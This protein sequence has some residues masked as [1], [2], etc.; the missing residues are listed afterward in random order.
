MNKIKRNVY[1]NVVIFLVC[2]CLYYI[3]EMIIKRDSHWSMI[4]CAGVASVITGLLN[5]IYSYDM[6]LQ[7][8]ML[9][10]AMVTTICE[11]LTGLL[12]VDIYGENTVW[13]YSELWGTF[14]YGQCNIFFCIIWF[15]LMFIAILI[16]D[17]IDYYL[18]DG[19]RPYYR[20]NKNEIWFWLSEN[21]TNT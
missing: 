1:S 14:F 7:L 15:F 21:K 10:G 11:G 5:N 19:E 13:N 20:L 2:G 16:A 4:L 17:S 18:F 6:L 3:I 12:L 8:Q 9:V